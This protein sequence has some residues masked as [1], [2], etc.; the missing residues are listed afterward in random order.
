MKDMYIDALDFLDQ[1]E[2]ERMIDYI[3]DM[4]LE[5]IERKNDLL[6]M[7]KD[8]LDKEIEIVRIAKESITMV[9]YMSKKG[10]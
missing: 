1:N 5:D 10:I 6:S 9:S 4:T 3:L 7:L 2:D 8:K